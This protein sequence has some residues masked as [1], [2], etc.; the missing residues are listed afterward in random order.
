MQQ[1]GSVDRVQHLVCKPDIH[2]STQS[3]LTFESHMK[4]LLRP[5]TALPIRWP[6]QHSNLQN[7]HP[8]LVNE[9]DRIE[10]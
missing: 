7:I 10:Y 8:G 9:T 4:Y 1:N 3:H 5:L 2:E 6:T